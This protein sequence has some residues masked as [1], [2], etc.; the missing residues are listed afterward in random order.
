MIPVELLSPTE[1]CGKN[2]DS[3]RVKK[4]PLSGGKKQ[5]AE[6]QNWTKN[7]ATS[8]RSWLKA[9][10]KSKEEEI[11]VEKIVSHNCVTL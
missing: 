11:S 2:K 4:S 6:Q 7:A 3:S 8:L 10:E 5:K 9:P 1:S